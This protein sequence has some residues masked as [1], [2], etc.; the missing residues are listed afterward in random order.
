MEKMNVKGCY[1]IDFENVNDNNKAFLTI[2][3]IHKHIPFEVKRIFLLSDIKEIKRGNHAHKKLHQIIISVQGSFLLK[4]DDGENKQEIFL[5]S[6]SKGVFVS[7]L[8]WKELT[9][10]SE[11]CKILVLASDYYDEGDY[12]RNYDDFLKIVKRY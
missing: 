8:V 10:F 5:D 4:L 12:I 2:I 1:I 6:P 9:N 7:N 11:D 3:Q